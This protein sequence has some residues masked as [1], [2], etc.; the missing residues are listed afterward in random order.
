[1]VTIVHMKL[2]SP[3]RRKM[4]A[5]TVSATS[6]ETGW[7]R[8]G[9]EATILRFSRKNSPIFWQSLQT[10]TA[11]SLSCYKYTFSKNIQ[12]SHIK[13][14]TYFWK[15]ITKIRPD[16]TQLISGNYVTSRCYFS[17][18]YVTN[19][20][21]PIRVTQLF[22]LIHSSQPKYREVVWSSE[23]ASKKSNHRIPMVTFRSIHSSRKARGRPGIDDA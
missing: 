2:I 6:L 10:S 11:S 4:H 20:V 19:M 17:G 18:K 23:A 1:M 5:H 13:W 8:G 3:L 14:N 22:P 7:G 9:A 16:Q 21:H 15:R 12:N